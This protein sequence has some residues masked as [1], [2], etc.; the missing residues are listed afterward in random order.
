[1]TLATSKKRRLEL[2]EPE[3]PYSLNFVGE[4]G[5]LRPKITY[6]WNISP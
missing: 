3:I 2:G 1:V 4:N 5:D 6:S